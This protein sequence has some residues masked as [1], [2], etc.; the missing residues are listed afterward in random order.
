MKFEEYAEHDGLG[1]AALVASGEVSPSEL[2]DIAIAR[3]EAVDGELNAVV[4]RL[5][6]HARAQIERG[7]PNGPFRG[8][9][10]LV[11][12]LHLQIAG[13]RTTNGC[14]LFAEAIADHDSTLTQRY[15]A[16][17]LVTFGRSASPEFG[18]STS[19]ESALFGRTHN[20]WKLGRTPGGSSGGAAAA[21]AAGVVPIANASDG[22][23]SIRIPASC[24]GVFGLKPT[25][26]RTPLGPTRAEGWNGLTSAHAVSRSVRDNAAL[27]DAT[28][29]AE[30]GDPY[31]APP[32]E[33]PYLDEVTADP[34]RLRIALM[35]TPPSGSAVDPECV[36]AAESAARLCEELGHRVEEAAPDYD[37]AAL[38]SAMGRTVWAATRL[39]LERRAAEL[40]RELREDDVEPATWT[41]SHWVDSVTGVTGVQAYTDRETIHAASRRAAAF[42]QDYDVLLS[43]V[44]GRPPVELGLFDLSKGD[45][46]EYF[47]QLGQ[48]SPFCSIANITGQPSMSLPLHWSADGLPIGVMFTGRYGDEATLLRLAGQLEQ[49]RPW[50]QRRPPL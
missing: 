42:H 50:A 2:L 37:S 44:L 27:L 1:L 30:A 24:C 32:Q 22:G 10:F 4:I 12:D 14:R 21:V 9:P 49:A 41:T 29:G 19:T 34:G 7:L 38:M 39:A 20:P 23:G 28:A 46:G 43:P 11:K 26:M 17:G 47:K 31:C 5:Y 18:G 8:V 48:F 33:R 45:L 3:S 25:R 13:T 16:A 40:G 35:R 15:D 6:D 36:E